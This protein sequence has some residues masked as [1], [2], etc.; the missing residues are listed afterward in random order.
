MKSTI[1]PL[2]PAASALRQK[3]AEHLT[4]QGCDL[5]D[6]EDALQRMVFKQAADEDKDKKTEESSEPGMNAVLEDVVPGYKSIG[7]LARATAYHGLGTAMNLSQRT[8]Y[9]M[10]RQYQAI[11]DAMRQ[12]EHLN[13]RRQRLELARRSLEAFLKQP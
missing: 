6:L 5:A 10:A 7:S 8:G 13:A 12:N 9:R 4:K 2:S 3:L 11:D 1:E